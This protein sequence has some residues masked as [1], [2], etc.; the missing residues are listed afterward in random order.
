[1]NILIITLTD[2]NIHSIR[3]EIEIFIKLS[4][5]NNNVIIMTNENGNYKTEFIKNNIKCI[6]TSLK[7]K[8]EVN[9]IKLIRKTIKENNI[10]IVYAMSSRTISNAIIG[11]MFLPPKLIIYRGTAG[12]LN[13]LDPTSYLNGLN[14]R[15]DGIICVSNDVKKSVFQQLRYRKKPKIETIYKGHNIKWYDKEKKADLLKLGTNQNNF[16]VVFVGNIRPHK[17]LQYF[18]ETAKKLSEFKKIYFILVCKN[19]KDNIIKNMILESEI[20]DRFYIAE[21]ISDVVNILK[22][23]DVLVHPSLSKEGLPRVILESL[24]SGTPVIASNNNSSLEIIEDGINGFIIPKKDSQAI[25]DKIKLLYHEP[26][27]LQKLKENT[28]KIINGKMS[29]IKTV[30]NHILFFKEILKEKK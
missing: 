2:G 24:A 15:V 12:G 11:C 28:K 1:M 17:G 22:S 20:R 4:K 21:N 19:L 18:I 16:N 27:T 9:T 14:P 23:C 30:E 3:P 7:K 6:E 5:L 8:I 10:E 25:A 13:K 29:H 26:E